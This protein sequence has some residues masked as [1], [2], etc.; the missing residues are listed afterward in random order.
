MLWLVFTTGK[1]NLKCTYC[2]G[3]FERDVVPYE[4]KYDQER[5]KRLIES[6]PQSTVVFYGGEPLIHLLMRSTSSF[7]RMFPANT[8]A[9][10]WVMAPVAAYFFPFTTMS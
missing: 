3:S 6:D 4:V 8:T 7:I 5:L 2:G 10:P 9:F 1:C